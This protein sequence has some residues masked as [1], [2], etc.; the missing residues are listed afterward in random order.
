MKEKV[1]K[2]LQ[3]IRPY[4]QAEGGDVE[5][6]DVTQEGVVKLKLKGACGACPMSTYT[7]KLGI[8]Q[9][10]KEKIPEVK[11]VEQVF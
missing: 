9:K 4:L 8:E 7:L 6:V 11:E 10:L 1:E 2:V 5:L 3:E